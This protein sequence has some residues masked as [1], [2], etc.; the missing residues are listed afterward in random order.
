MLNSCKGWLKSP[1]LLS[2]IS[3]L[4]LFSCKPTRS[5]SDPSGYF[6]DGK[7][8]GYGSF[9]LSG[10]PGP[11][12]LTIVQKSGVNNFDSAREGLY[13]LFEKSDKENP[14]VFV[15]YHPDTRK[16]IIYN[17]KIVTKAST[18]E[19]GRIDVWMKL[20]K[21]APSYTDSKT[22]YVYIGYFS[23][24]DSKPKMQLYGK[25]NSSRITFG[26]GF[27]RLALHYAN[28]NIR[29]KKY[30]K[31]YCE[32]ALGLP[33]SMKY[34]LPAGFEERYCAPVTPVGDICDSKPSD[35]NCLPEIPSEFS[36]LES[37]DSS[38]KLEN[39]DLLKID[40][41]RYRMVGN[42]TT[43]TIAI[44]LG[45]D[46]NSEN[47]KKIQIHTRTH[48]RALSDKCTV[49]LNMDKSI[50]LNKFAFNVSIQDAVSYDDKVCNLIV[51]NIK[52]GKTDFL[53][54]IGR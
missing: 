7:Q 37:K 39:I 26:D 34:Q 21:S 9:V 36:A 29:Q 47:A 48:T 25:V 45:E 2:F 4:V 50:S 5:G 35:K 18:Q 1:K 14:V 23:N 22:T 16:P 41:S 51:E 15:D 43:G 27:N 33:D 31:S 20:V 11:V 30:S 38:F 52:N 44:D 19:V 46:V 6:T 40:S 17:H 28:S 10:E 3:L 24:T 49:S 42:E 13:S 12:E 32:V 8:Y 54:V 53:Q